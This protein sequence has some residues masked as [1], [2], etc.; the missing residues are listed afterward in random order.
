MKAAKQRTILRSKVSKRR[1]TQTKESVPVNKVLTF[2]SNVGKMVLQ[3]LNLVPAVTKVIESSAGQ[4]IPVLDKLDQIGS[5]VITAEGMITSVLGPGSGAQKA[6]AVGPY[7]AQVILSSSLVA[8]KKM[9]PEKQQ[10][11]MDACTAIGSDVADVLNCFEP[12]TTTIA[13]QNVT[14]SPAPTAVLT[15]AKA[16][17]AAPTPIAAPT[18]VPSAAP[19]SPATV[20]AVTSQI[21]DAP[22]TA[23]AIAAGLPTE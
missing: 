7:V 12:D 15:P 4:P 9:A 6:K 5:L 11:F 17:A 23:A 20:E 22:G 10:A 16:A 14:A 3:G 21:P 1:P 2:L 8:G 18:P 13:S 19:V